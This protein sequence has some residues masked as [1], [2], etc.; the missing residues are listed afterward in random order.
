LFFKK[1]RPV[2]LELGYVKPGE[3]LGFYTKHDTNFS[4][5]ERHDFIYTFR[6]LHRLDWVLK[7]MEAE[8]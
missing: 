8:K 7:Q 5:G 3:D 4:N 6:N 1:L 2:E